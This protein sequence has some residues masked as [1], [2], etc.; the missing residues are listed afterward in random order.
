MLNSIIPS[1]GINLYSLI[2]CSITS[3]ILGLIIGAIHSRTTKYTKNFIITL[4]V[5]PILVQIVMMMV[6]GNLGTSVAIVGAF[7]LIRF[8]S[9]P[10]T[11]KEIV[12][13]FFAMAV[14]LATGTGYLIFAVIVTIIIGLVFIILNKAI[15]TNKSKLLV[16]NMP[17]N[18]ND[19][20]VLNDIF[21][22]Y[23]IDYQLEKTKTVNMGSIFELTY[24]LNYPDNTDEI[25]LLNKLRTRNGNLKVVLMNDID[26]M[27]SL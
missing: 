22:Q 17:E 13:V 23:N 8:R 3:I 24:K 27:E 1:T 10:G 14:G 7:S 12:S 5:L 16:I 2:L 6:N 25:K 15:K 21:K 4:C 20:N 9:M 18:L 19:I 26:D 11:S